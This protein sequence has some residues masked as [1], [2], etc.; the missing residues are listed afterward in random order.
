MTPNANRFL[1]LG[2]G[3]LICFGSR[4]AAG[5]NPT[6]KIVFP[7]S[8]TVK[9]SLSTHRVAGH[10]EPG[11]TLTL[12][13]APLRVYSTGAFAG[14]LT[15]KPGLNTFTFIATSS[16]GQT[17][18]ELKITRSAPGTGIAKGRKQFVSTAS[19]EPRAALLVRVGDR[20]RVRCRAGASLPVVYKIG[21]KRSYYPTEETSPGLYEGEFV[22]QPE[23]VYNLAR[24]TFY[25]N[26]GSRLGSVRVSS[27][28]ALAPG[29]ITVMTDRVPKVVRVT[30]DVTS[31]YQE[32]VGHAR[33]GKAV[34]GTRLRATGRYG[35]RWRVALSPVRS[36]WISGQYVTEL[37]RGSRVV[38]DGFDSAEVQSERDVHLVSLQRS[39]P[40]AYT[41]QETA[42]PDELVVRFHDVAPEAYWTRQKGDGFIESVT[43]VAPGDGTL[44]YRLGLSSGLWG[45]RIAYQ[46]GAMAIRLRP[47]PSLKQSDDDVLKNLVICLDP[48]H[49]GADLGAIG[50]TALDE[51]TANLTLATSMENLFEAQGARVVLTRSNDSAV[52][53]EE[54]LVI[55]ERARADL[56]ISLHCNAVAASAD[57]LRAR[58]PSVHYFHPV[59]QRFAGQVGRRL[60]EAAGRHGA[61]LYGVVEQSLYV[62]RETTWIPSI[63][64][65]FGFLTHPEDEASLLSSSDVSEMVSAVCQGAADFARLSRD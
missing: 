25:F 27:T 43:R 11:A 47:A 57:P 44:Q 51:K 64:V 17:R 50:G 23:D 20:V 16:G 31:L 3:L 38:R 15:L 29:S 6:L 53:L 9:T 2:A 49:G 4:G 34:R 61:P 65:E 42:G 10:T 35:D 5:V 40:V 21:S 32:A 18:R 39:A 58:G 41:V 63:L 1:I 45:Y 30:A 36:A 14:L 7:G 22:I 55:A 26:E 59:S 8:A 28:K 24:V 62:T 13:G 37:P 54:R 33:V 56:F 46:S 52:S 60:G 19:F 48:G 12:D